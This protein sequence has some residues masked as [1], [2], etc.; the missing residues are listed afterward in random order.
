[1]AVLQQKVHRANAVLW[2]ASA[3]TL[4]ALSIWFLFDFVAP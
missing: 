3:L 1:M 2:E 4:T